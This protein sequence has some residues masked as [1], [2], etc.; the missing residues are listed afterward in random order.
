MTLAVPGPVGEQL[1][2]AIAR[3]DV[4][5]IADCF[6]PEAQFRAL[7]PPGLR[8]RQGV[9]EAAALIAALLGIPSPAVS[10]A[11]STHDGSHRHCAILLG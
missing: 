8:E 11:L 1:V 3:Q 9:D 6:T 2:R 10:A 4:G 5:A 7:I